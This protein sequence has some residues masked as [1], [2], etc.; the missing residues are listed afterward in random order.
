[1]GTE[2]FLTVG[3]SGGN[4][5]KKLDWQ[6]RQNTRLKARN[7]PTRK[8][9]KISHT[10]AR[11][12]LAG[13]FL[14][15]IALAQPATPAKTP[16]P[17]AATIPLFL[18]GKQV[19]TTKLAAGT[20][21]EVVRETQSELVV[22]YMGQEIRL[23]KK[24]EPSLPEATPAPTP[25][26]EKPE[27]TSGAAAK[28]PIKTTKEQPPLSGPKR[29]VSSLMSEVAVDDAKTNQAPHLQEGL[30]MN[31][32]AD[33][34]RVFQTFLQ[35]GQIRLH[36]E[37]L[38]PGARYRIRVEL[39]AGKATRE[40][41]GIWPKDDSRPESLIFGGQ[42]L[43][44]TKVGQRVPKVL[45]SDIPEGT[46]STGNLDV[47]IAC[48][49]VAAAASRI[50]ITS[51]CPTPLPATSKKDAP[52]E[53]NAKRQLTSLDGFLTESGWENPPTGWIPIGEVGDEKTYYTPAG[54]SFCG[55][56]GVFAQMRLKGGRL[57][58]LDIVLAEQSLFETDAVDSTASSS[59][60]LEASQ[61]A[62]WTD[63]ARTATENVT[64]TLTAQFGP[65]KKIY[66]D[67]ETRKNPQE[68]STVEYKTGAPSG[69][70]EGLCA[71]VTTSP[72]IVEVS[73]EWAKD[74]SSSRMRKDSLTKEARTIK[75]KASIKDRPNGDRILNIVGSD[76]SRSPY[77]AQGTITMVA[78]ALGFETNI[79]DM[80]AHS[81]YRLV[82]LKDKPGRTAQ[83]E[84]TFQWVADCLKMKLVTV[85]AARFEDIQRLIDSGTPIIL[86]RFINGDRCVHHKELG[87]SDPLQEPE[88]VKGPVTKLWPTRDNPN[89][90]SGGHASLITG[91]NK[92]RRELILSESWGID[93]INAERVR[94]EEVQ[95]T[96]TDY[97][98]L[99][100]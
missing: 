72:V 18:N 70:P 74:A 12:S 32:T 35:P 59:Q 97:F 55:V 10:V 56:A 57:H 89:V 75:S 30:R 46:Y 88:P 17:E 29:W 23:P 90:P 34:G 52:D 71:R 48:S 81:C 54:F 33:G 1:M 65:G 78:T 44:K 43:G 4:M 26:K 27:E 66:L 40:R 22:R 21:V 85:K 58:R 7:M 9:I 20:L 38:E 98:W 6:L 77:C 91:Y 42:T 68:P 99:V 19:G 61:V 5:R 37:G 69:S 47:E 100:P 39:P 45:E 49:E 25:Q 73:L 67:L 14:A 82:P 94:M 11:I 95:A 84:N 83:K 2:M 31:L 64:K 60:K 80:A 50:V 16:L 76:Q 86:G 13:I 51:N 36:Y 79:Y 93:F 63:A 53:E 96:C 41:A 92:A 28:E 24:T 8:Q 15:D 62:A 3:Y 87:M